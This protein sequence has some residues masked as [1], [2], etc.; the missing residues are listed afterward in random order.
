MQYAQRFCSTPGYRDGLFWNEAE[1]EPSSP[2]GPLFVA[3]SEEG[4]TPGEIC[5]ISP[6]PYHGYHY[7]ILAAQGPDAPGGAYNYVINGH[8][9]AGFAIVAWPAEYAVSGIMTFIVNQN[10]IVYEKN[11]GPKTE[12]AIMAMK[13]YD[14]DPEWSRAQ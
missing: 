3:A 13:E 2:L 5:M 14:P 9:V 6:A 12:E 4:Y 7:K 11:L 10:G 8:M 1:G